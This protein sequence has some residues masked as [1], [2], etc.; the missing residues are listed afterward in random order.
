ML[1][2]GCPDTLLNPPECLATLTER[3]RLI[4]L[5]V[6]SGTRAIKDPIARRLDQNDVVVLTQLSQTLHRSFLLGQTLFA[7]RLGLE[8]IEV[9]GQVHQGIRTG[10]VQQLG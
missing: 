8:P 1:R 6:R 10:V 3:H 9:I 7:D 2:T 5:A 4:L